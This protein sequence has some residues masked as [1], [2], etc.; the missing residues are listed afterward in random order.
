MHYYCITMLITPA[1]PCGGTA[2]L[3][4][5][6]PKT[7][8]TK[9]P[10][11]TNLN[12]HF[13]VPPVVALAAERRAASKVFRYC[14]RRR[15][16][17]DVVGGEDEDEEYGYNE[18][19]A[20]LEVYSQS[21]REEALIVTAIVDDEEVEVIIFKG[22]SSCLSGETAVDPARSVLPERAVIIKIDR[23]RG[24]FDPSQIHYIQKGLSFQAFK[25]TRLLNS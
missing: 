8:L 19:M 7:Q 22:V 11:S 18:E 13:T 25:E 23:V 17:D 12:S 4:V 1:N 9:I 3:F 16:R 6:G 5:F 15:V 10:S 2:G 21:C 20:M 24:P 14:A